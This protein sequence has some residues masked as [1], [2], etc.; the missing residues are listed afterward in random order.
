MPDK[1]LPD[2]DVRA[3]YYTNPLLKGLI[4]P[5]KQGNYLDKDLKHKEY[6][7]RIYDEI[8]ANTKRNSNAS[9]GATIVPAGFNPD[10]EKN[11]RSLKEKMME[12]GTD[13][14]GLSSSE[15]D[16]L[17]K[18]VSRKFPTSE[19]VKKLYGQESLDPLVEALGHITSPPP[20]RPKPSPSPSASPSPKPSPSPATSSS[21]SPSPSPATSSRPP[22]PPPSRAQV[23]TGAPPQ[24]KAFA[25][26]PTPRDAGNP[27]SSQ[28]RNSPPTSGYS[29]KGRQGVLSELVEHLVRIPPTSGYSPKGKQVNPGEYRID[30]FSDIVPAAS[31]AGSDLGGYL[32][33]TKNKLYNL[34]FGGSLPSNNMSRDRNELMMK[35]GDLYTPEQYD[36]M[37]SQFAPTAPLLLNFTHNPQQ[38]MYRVNSYQPEEYPSNVYPEELYSLH[39]PYTNPNTLSRASLGDM[40][41]LRMSYKPAPPSVISPELSGPPIG[42]KGAAPN[43]PFNLE[44]IPGQ[45]PPTIPMETLPIEPLPIKFMP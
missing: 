24:P 36:L 30:S 12:G 14:Y 43:L 10:L 4:S 28:T 22:S 26:P 19:G 9:P 6:I 45:I 34:L 7:R 20:S 1:Y 40:T 44:M 13:R 39:R 8:I 33:T 35:Y 21:P 32:E 38:M 15:V 11:L 2:S 42:L 29:P 5:D 18:E 27:P 23:A 25:P 17:F 41:P 37:A 3:S 31:K 16:D